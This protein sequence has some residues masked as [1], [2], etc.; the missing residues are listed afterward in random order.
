MTFSDSYRRMLKFV[1]ICHWTS[2]ALR[3][4][5]GYRVTLDFLNP[6]KNRTPVV[7]P[8]LT[9]I[10]ALVEFL[11]EDHNIKLWHNEPLTKI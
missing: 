5:W 9:S 4:G 10:E 6:I 1:D 8:S 2:L 7:L 3:L 11:K